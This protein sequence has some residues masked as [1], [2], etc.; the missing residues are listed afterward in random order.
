MTA[1]DTCV[2]HG[3]AVD[4]DIAYFSGPQASLDVEGLSSSGPSRASAQHYMSLRYTFSSS[5][6]LEGAGPS[7]EPALQPSRLSILHHATSLEL[8]R[9]FGLIIRASESAASTTKPTIIT[10]SVSW[11]ISIATSV[12]AS[13]L[14]TVAVLVL[15]MSMLMIVPPRTRSIPLL[16]LMILVRQTAPSTLP[17]VLTIGGPAW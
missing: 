9:R 15:T 2:Q 16:T 5:T 7:H 13:A 17:A 3:G 4:D 1:L 12:F 8:D 14:V 10:V 11:P 6:A